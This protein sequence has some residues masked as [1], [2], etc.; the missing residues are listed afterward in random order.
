M[1]LNVPEADS[2][3]GTPY[4]IKAW[5]V[6]VSWV[7]GIVSPNSRLVLVVEEKRNFAA[8]GCSSFLITMV[9]T[10]HICG[11]N[12]N[13]FAYVIR[14]LHEC[15]WQTNE[16]HLS[17]RRDRP[18]PNHL[19]WTVH[20]CSKQGKK[21]RTVNTLLLRSLF[22]VLVRLTIWETAVHDKRTFQTIIFTRSQRLCA[23]HVISCPSRR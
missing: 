19:N 9:F 3:G 5:M 14:H 21:Q 11:V 23:I 2:H 7:R 8:S 15:M 10:G 16:C 18:Q 12:Q 20:K 22:S 1:A 17:S 13:N 4:F 6:G